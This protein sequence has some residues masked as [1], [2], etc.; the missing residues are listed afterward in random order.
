MKD[1]KEQGEGKK[2]ELGSR[3]VSSFLLRIF[4]RFFCFFFSWVFS[5]SLQDF[6]HLLKF[7]FLSPRLRCFPRF[8]LP[9]HSFSVVLLFLPLSLNFLSFSRVFLF[10]FCVFLFN[11]ACCRFCTCGFFPFCASV[12]LL[13]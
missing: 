7:S 8:F 9:F 2:G 3:T 10:H 1:G 5:H 6:F 13:T 4:F 12:S 11:S